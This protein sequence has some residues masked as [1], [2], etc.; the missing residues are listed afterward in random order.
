MLQMGRL[1]LRGLRDKFL[2][3]ASLCPALRLPEDPG[4][5]GWTH[6]VPSARTPSL[7]WRN[8]HPSDLT[9]SA[10]LFMFINDF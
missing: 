1:S 9:P 7:L 4:L 2:A 8:A 6:M 10:L 5:P 3:P